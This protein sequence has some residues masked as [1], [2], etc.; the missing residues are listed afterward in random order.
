MVF[1]IRS[2]GLGASGH[3]NSGFFV[4]ASIANSGHGMSFMSC[5][6]RARQF[7]RGIV[8]KPYWN[9]YARLQFVCRVAGRPAGV[10]ANTTGSFSSARYLSSNSSVSHYIDWLFQP[11]SNKHS[12]VSST[13]SP[14]SLD[15]LLSSRRDLNQVLG[16]S[17]SRLRQSRIAPSA[18]NEKLSI[19]SLSL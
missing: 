15:Y 6:D 16:S 9:Q 7:L 12:S 2:S 18:I 13:H 19:Y 1:N 11:A 8:R 14:D 4:Y 10:L 5:L 17:P 3:R